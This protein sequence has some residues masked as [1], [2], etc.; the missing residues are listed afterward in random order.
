[1]Y[2]LSG[3]YLEFNVKIF[4]KGW[5]WKI[6]QHSVDVGGG[7]ENFSVAEGAKRLQ[8]SNRRRGGGYVNFWDL[9]NN[10]NPPP[11]PLKPVKLKIFDRVLFL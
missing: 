2:C 6:S 10:N 3:I 4:V 1:M 7:Y 8:K 9:K 5:E 11:P